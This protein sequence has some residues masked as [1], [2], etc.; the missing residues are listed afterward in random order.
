MRRRVAPRRAAGNGYPPS[1]RASG[2]RPVHRPWR[3]AALCALLLLSVC[4]PA[5]G[6][7]PALE[8]YSRAVRVSQQGA[9]ETAV[10]MLQELVRDHGDDPIADDALFQIASIRE[11]QLGDFDRAEETYTLLMERFPRS[12]NAGTAKQRLD[13]LRADRATG[14]EPL[15]IFNDIQGRFAALGEPEALRRLRDLYQDYPGFCRRDDVLYMIAEA[16][17]RGKDYDAALRHYQTLVETYPDSER[18]YHV[19]GKI[20]KAHIERRDFDAALRAF[21][22]VAA[23]EERVYGARISW[24]G[25][26]AQIRLFRL[27]RSLFLLSLCLT[28]GAAAFWLL[29]TRWRAVKAGTLKAAA[30]PAAVLALVFLL[31]VSLAARKPWMF[32]STLLSTGAAVTAAAFLHHLFLGTRPL[33]PRGR[34]LATAGAFLAAAALVYAVYYHQ[35]MVNLLYDSIHYSLEKG[36]W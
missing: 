20:G 2:T 22:Q 10:E 28:A 17:Q 24:E 33:A 19:L 21:E 18:V 1:P 23:Y 3:P 11:K 31:A 13:R 7:Q 16:E 34:L 30:V 4:V 9:P 14:D 26:M 12:K 6:Q 29:G 27:L 32:G 25:H 5:R 8:T 15:R 35:D 36:Q